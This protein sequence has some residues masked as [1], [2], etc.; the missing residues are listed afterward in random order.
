MQ[1]T[2]AHASNAVARS[3]FGFMG[4]LNLLLSAS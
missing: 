4:S 2:A 3:G 1:D